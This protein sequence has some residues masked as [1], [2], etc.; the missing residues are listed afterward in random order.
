[1]KRCIDVIAVFM[2]ASA[3]VN[4]TPDSSDLLFNDS[5]VQDYRINFYIPDW[6]DSLIVNKANDEIYMPARL[7]WH[8]PS[9]DS[10]V[11][12]SIGLRYKGNSSYAIASE[13]KPFKF[14]FN[15]Y[16]KNQLFFSLEKLNFSNG[17]QD[18]TMM[19][20]KMA[21][22]V[23]GKYMP[24]PRASFATLTVEDTLVKAFYTQVEQVDELFLMRHFGSD[25]NN[26]YKA[27]DQG[28]TLAYKSVNQSAYEGDYE[29]KTNEKE[30]VWYGLISMLDKLNNTPEGDFVKE[31]GACLD[32]DNCIRYL[33]FNM[34]N[35]NFDSY[36]G[37]ARNYY[38]YDDGEAGKFKLIPWDVNL[39]FA[40]YPYTW[41]DNLVG[42]DAF[43]PS[44]IDQRPLEKRILANDSLKRVY[45]EYM[46][47]MI[48]GPLSVDSVEALAHRLKSIIDSSVNADV[49]KFYTYEQFVTNIDSDLVF[50]IGPQ[51]TILPGLTSFTMERNEHLLS[52]I[53]KVLPVV[54]GPPQR[55]GGEAPALH[56]TCR[57][58][59]KHITVRYTAPA[60][61]AGV[62]IEMYDARG[63]LRRSYC[64]GSK[65]R[66]CHS[67]DLDARSLPSGYYA[68][69]LRAG[70]A[71]AS[72]GML[73]MNSD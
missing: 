61:A 27:G 57:A 26:L 52:Q 59:G 21:Y 62:A 69:V 68:I 42:V 54:Y 13:K 55:K 11:L 35:A 47:Q 12:D 40:A 43:S 60:S 28:A 16:R 53:E 45:A 32:L 51:M 64:G 9:G 72:R 65:S 10:I 48:A 14:F 25:K 36:T 15:K 73:L 70:T 31:V 66:G 24:A 7:T 8:G 71:T 5:V 17:V 33:A 18:P 41:K 50:K 49:R 1:M 19:R 30:N 29:L 22:D 34:V 2:A 4:A 38:L 46:Q 39:S 67:I 56:F 58:S 20:E 23:V 37:S 6:H 63:E 3:C 44:N